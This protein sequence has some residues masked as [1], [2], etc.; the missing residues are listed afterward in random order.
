MN[1]DRQAIQA[2][3]VIHVQ[4]KW[5]PA[6]QDE[7]TLGQRDHSP[8]RGARLGRTPPR[9]QW[10]TSDARGNR[11]RGPSCIALGDLGALRG[12]GAGEGGGWSGTVLSAGCG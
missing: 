10:E 1:D 3:V 2:G 6:L 12:A 11:G 7:D 9:K 8:P 5:S 4:S